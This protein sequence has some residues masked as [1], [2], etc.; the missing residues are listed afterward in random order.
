MPVVVGET[1][2]QDGDAGGLCC[3]DAFGC[4]HWQIIATTDKVSFDMWGLL[5]N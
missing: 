5:S 3:N 2:A 4:S 1:G